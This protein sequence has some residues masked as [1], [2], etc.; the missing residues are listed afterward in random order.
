[1]SSEYTV[2]L[3]DEKITIGRRR[4]GNGA[5]SG[6]V[7]EFM[8]LFEIRQ[9]P[10]EIITVPQDEMIDLYDG[11]LKPDTEIE[12][13]SVGKTTWE[14]LKMKLLSNEMGISFNFTGSRKI[15]QR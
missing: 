3:N 15:Y 8:P 13:E 14:E 10:L 5:G 4:A 1:M 2:E 12:I 11:I 7:F 9:E 6:M